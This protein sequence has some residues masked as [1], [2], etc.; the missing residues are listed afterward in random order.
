MENT[1][2]HNNP[3]Y[4]KFKAGT[5]VLLRKKGVQPRHMIK[6][7]P[8]Y[9]SQPFRI[10][11]CTQ[12]NAVI[13]PF[14]LGYLEKRFKYEGDIPRNLCTLQRLSNL[15]PI[16][17]PFKLLKLSF[18]QKMLLDLNSLLQSDY[19]PVSVVEIVNQKTKDQ[20]SKLIQDFNASVKFIPNPDHDQTFEKKNLQVEVPQHNHSIEDINKVR[21]HSF[22]HSF[23]NSEL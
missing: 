18:S 6:A 7:N 10:L 14:G 11:R 22:D 19:P 4:E 20:P 12:T 2:S 3:A 23:N 21:L 9:H 1:K 5:F 15:K 8:V 16:K 17:N 13:V